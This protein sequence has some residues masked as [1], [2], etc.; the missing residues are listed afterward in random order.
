MILVEI[1]I[2]I[3]MISIMMLKRL[4]STTNLQQ[5]FLAV[6]LLRSRGLS[7]C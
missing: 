6:T 3:F 5:W 7:A 4:E 1:I 2:F